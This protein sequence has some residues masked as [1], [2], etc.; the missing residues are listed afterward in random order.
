MMGFEAFESNFLPQ[1]SISAIIAKYA[2]NGYIDILQEKWYGGLPCF[3]LGTEA[4][5]Q[6]KPLGVD[7]VIGVF[8]LLGMGMIMGLLILFLEHLFFR[9][10]LPHLR[11]KPKDSIWRSRN[12]MF[13]SQ[14]C[15]ELFREGLYLIP[16]SFPLFPE[17]LQIY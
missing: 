5:A 2:S 12:I 7:A 13:F 17:T 16:T 14:V 3:K 10:S 9:Y 15:R 1:D 8:I 4:L 11:E 6:P